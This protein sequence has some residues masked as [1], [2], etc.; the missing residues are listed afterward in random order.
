MHI[1][2]NDA[3]LK[4]VLRAATQD[5]DLNL[6]FEPGLDTRAHGLNLKAVALDELLDE[7]LPRL[8][9]ACTRQGRNLFIRKRGD[10]LRFYHVEQLAMAR[11]GTKSFQVNASGQVIQSLGAGASAGAASS[12]AYTSSVQMGQVNDLWADL[13]SGLLLLVFGRTQD[14]QVASQANPPGSRGYSGEGRNLLIQP[15]PGLVAVEADPA[16]H[17]RVAA[18][19]DQIRQRIGRQVLLEARIVE[20]TLGNDSQIGVDWT[21]LL[22]SSNHP[23]LSFFRTGGD[24]SQDQGLLRIVAQSGRVEATLSAL[25]RDH[26]LKV[27]SA[28]RLSALNNQKAILRVVREEAYAVPSSQITP[29]SAAGGA[30]AT[31]QLTPLIVPVGIVLDI[32]AQ[33]GDDGVITLGVNPSISEVVEERDF[34]VP[35]PAGGRDLSRTRLPVVDRR[36]LDTVVRIRSGETLVLAGI[37]RTKETAANRGVPWLR[38]LPVL[39]HLF[40]L[41]KKARVRTELAIFISPTLMED[42]AQVATER[43]GA[44]DRLGRAGAEVKP[45]APN[46][47]PDPGTP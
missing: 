1:T 7:V 9:L 29:G 41:D 8:G 14:R 16:T 13:E 21:G 22:S 46:P 28:P 32:Q 5:T 23:A 11:N 33:I 30:I 3:D 38:H 27:L 43:Q 39:G 31:G 17:E 36:D 35:N 4:D 42:S 25:A 44:E 47:I 2:V 24:L 6:I 45:P 37:I 26:R 15:N 10:G 19:L 18:Y 20:V 34:G 40:A 12:S